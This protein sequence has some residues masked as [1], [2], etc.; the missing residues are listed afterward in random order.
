MA[1]I[2]HG[3]AARRVVRKVLSTRVLLLWRAA[4]RTLSLSV[5]LS[6]K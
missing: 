3:V 4:I 6:G 2:A 1:N 5:S